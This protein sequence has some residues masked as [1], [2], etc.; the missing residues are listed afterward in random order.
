MKSPPANVTEWDQKIK[1]LINDLAQNRGEDALSMVLSILSVIGMLNVLFF[2][3]FGISSWPIGLIRGTKSA[4]AQAEEI[5]DSHLINQTRINALRDKE[6]FGSKLTV[7]ERRQLSKLE[8]HERRISREEQHLDDYR[9]S[10]YYKL[11]RII[12]PLEILL[13]CFAAA[14]ALI[15]WLSLLLTK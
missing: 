11:R 6:R 13:G 14:L 3:G 4:R 7:R 1:F 15:V 9:K 8:D 12:R 10:V 2:T 5:Q